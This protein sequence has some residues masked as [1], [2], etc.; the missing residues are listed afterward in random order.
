MIV[1]VY[2]N[3]MITRNNARENLSEV[4]FREYH[5]YLCYTDVMANAWKALTTI[6][7]L[8]QL[9]CSINV[10]YYNNICQKCVGKDCND[11]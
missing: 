1:S 11:I 10:I 9:K 3:Y 4:P 2:K 5:I 7:Y 8:V 6:L